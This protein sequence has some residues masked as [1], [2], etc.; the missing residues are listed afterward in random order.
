MRV[1]SNSATRS[2]L[3]GFSMILVLMRVVA[4]GVVV[5]QS[6]DGWGQPSCGENRDRRERLHDERIV[7]FVKFV[8]VK[9]C[10]RVY[11]R[12]IEQLALDIER[13]TRMTGGLSDAETQ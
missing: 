12:Q 7:V 11:K 8:R 6:Q 9:E 1:K 5:R 10:V 3:V 2:S 13:G 4:A